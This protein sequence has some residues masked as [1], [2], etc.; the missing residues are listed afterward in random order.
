VQHNKDIFRDYLEQSR[1]GSFLIS[2]YHIVLPYPNDGNSVT[3]SI[4]SSKP[5][6]TFDDNSTRSALPK[7]MTIPSITFDEMSKLSSFPP[8]NFNK[9][10]RS[11]ADDYSSKYSQLEQIKAD[12]V[13]Y[14]TP[15]WTY[16]P[17]PD[18]WTGNVETNPI[19]A[20]GNVFVTTPANFVVSLQAHSGVENWK[21]SIP[22]PGRRG[23]LWWPGNVTQ[24]PR[25]FVPSSDGVY[26][27]NPVDGSLIKTFGT[28]GHVGSAASLIPPAVD[29][30]RLIIATVAPSVEAYD[31]E[32]GVLLWKTSLLDT[33]HP[34]N[35][36]DF[37]L[38]GGSPWG[39]LSLDANRSRIYVSTGNPRPQM[40]GVNRP[41]KNDFS[42]SVTSIDTKTGT[43]EWSFQ[44]VKHDLWDLDVPAPPILMKVRKDNILID[45]VAVV[46]KL[47]NT[48]LLDRE[49]GKPVFD[50][51]LR[52]A[53][54]STVPRER[55]WPYQPDIE[56]P[57]PFSTTT[58]LPSDITDV[59]EEER[60]NV[61]AKIRNAQFG[62]FVPPV[63]NGKVVSFGVHGGAEWPGAAVDP[64]TG[65]L[66]VPSNRDPWILRL[67]YTERT[68]NPVRISDKVGDEVYQRKCANCH[69]VRREGYYDRE[70][71]IAGDTRPVGD[72][73]Y[74]S[75]IGITA[76]RNIEGEAWFRDAHRFIKLPSDVTD[77]EIEI[78]DRYLSA[79]DHF[80]DERKSLE[81]SYQWGLL[82]DGRG[83]PGS[84]PPWGSI[85]AI[86]LNTG[87]R[88][89]S[90]PFG[91]YRDLTER[92]L[93]ITGQPNFGGV[94]ATK[95]GI[96]F[97]TGTIDKKVRAF[98]K[99]TG[100]ELWK[101]DLPAAG[102]APPVTFEID[103]VQYLVVVATGGIF[104]GFDARSGAIVAF[105][106]DA[107]RK[108]EGD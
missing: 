38:T 99:Q 16:N 46:T 83:H 62:F 95:G 77:D 39:G 90:V 47:G 41:G 108:P 52:R 73:A 66:Y 31:V 104:G 96:I 26:A 13:K 101:Y 70:T 53:P 64:D 29:Q 61:L 85:T 86:D 103:G 65:I 2:A 19:F 17:Q 54:V 71:I 84:K 9:W 22:M 7:F 88:V 68:P 21:T 74:P 15:A 48:L 97:A 14:L 33:T 69:G 67:I 40:Y 59:G 11:G 25:L 32:S 18:T 58:F 12:N 45:A 78:I 92:G 102:T 3:Y 60:A 10:E 37:R 76:D 57:E 44:E 100:A 75:L 81:V 72:T 94:I 56:L 105:R 27:L 63:I 20:S 93:P 89:W 23:L 34:P 24:S 28:D 8:I 80:S 98:D 87:R 4:F 30:N 51:R 82:L 55:T 107:T 36:L 6:D 50:F 43:I 42:C 106:L 49:L 1:V 91:E 79:A 5:S 35:T